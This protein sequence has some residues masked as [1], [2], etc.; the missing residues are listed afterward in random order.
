MYV[1]APGGPAP[2]REGDDEMAREVITIEMAS[3]YFRRFLERQG[4]HHD[5]ERFGSLSGFDRS[6]G[7]GLW[8]DEATVSVTARYASFNREKDVDVAFEV[9]LNWSSTRRT[10]AQAAA[11]LIS[12]REAVEFAA[13][14]ESFCQELPRVIVPAQAAEA[15]G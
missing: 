7:A 9:K 8:A 14:C 4:I 13:R 6:F 3:E 15:E 5:F 12:Y 10:V 11:A 2:A 1:T